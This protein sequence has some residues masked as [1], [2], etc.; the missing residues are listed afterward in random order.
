MDI[1]AH[2]VGLHLTTSNT[3]SNSVRLVHHRLISKK[4]AA[5]LFTCRV[6][7]LRNKLL[8]KILQAETLS[9]KNFYMPIIS[10]SVIILT[11]TFCFY[12]LFYPYLILYRK[13]YLCFLHAY[14]N[15]YLF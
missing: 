2:K 1:S 6:P 14:L 12:D 11:F 8:I 5:A 9:L 4:C 3:R 15:L 13:A 7:P 10:T